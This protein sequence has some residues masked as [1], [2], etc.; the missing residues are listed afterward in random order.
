M[1]WMLTSEGT[2][3]VGLALN[4]LEAL[5]CSAVESSSQSTASHVS[6]LM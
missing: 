4:Y 6:K 2:L 3:M 1:T 5:G